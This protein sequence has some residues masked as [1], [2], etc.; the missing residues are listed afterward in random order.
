MRMPLWTEAELKD[1]L[2]NHCLDAFSGE[3]RI[4]AERRIRR[5]KFHS[6]LNLLCHIWD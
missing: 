2:C 1:Y 5:L 4:A 3:Q 6:A